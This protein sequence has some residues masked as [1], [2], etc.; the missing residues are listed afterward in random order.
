MNFNNLECRNN[1]EQDNGENKSNS[2]GENHQIEQN[3]DQSQQVEQS[4]ELGIIRQ[5]IVGDPMN[6]SFGAEDSHEIKDISPRE[7]IES[8]NHLLPGDQYAA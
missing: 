4:N 3:H 2:E 5:H 8:D 1:S 6:F 7:I